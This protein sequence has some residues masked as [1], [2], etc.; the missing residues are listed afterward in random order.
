MTLLVL[1][2]HIRIVPSLLMIMFYELQYWCKHEPPLV[3]VFFHL[4]DARRTKSVHIQEA[5]W[6]KSRYVFSAE[7]MQSAQTVTPDSQFP[8]SQSATF[9]LIMFLELEVARV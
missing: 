1:P 3:I 8:S 5:E 9:D 2:V 6:L 7:G 4:H